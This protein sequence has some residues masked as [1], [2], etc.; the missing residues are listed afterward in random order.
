E[1]DPAKRPPSGVAVAETLRAVL[2]AVRARAVG[3]PG[4]G[5]GRT[6]SFPSGPPLPPGLDE[7]W[8]VNLREGPQFPA[9]LTAAG[10]FLL[11]GQ[12]SDA[13]AVLR[14]ADGALHATFDLGDEAS[15]PPL[16]NA[17]R[18]FVTSRDGA[19]QA[20]SWPGGD[21]LWRR[22]DADVVG[23]APYGRDAVVAAG[24]CVALWAAEG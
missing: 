1:K 13:L 4:A 9:G 2:A 23:G 6:H 11:V 16:F 15:Q 24:E 20:L 10:G 8:R 12:R 21:L 19:M 5:P 22:E 7:R 17:G 3:L 18:V 14:P